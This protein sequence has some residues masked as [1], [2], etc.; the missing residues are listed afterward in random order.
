M[1]SSLRRRAFALA[2]SVAVLAAALVAPPSA[3]GAGVACTVTYTT[4]DWDTGFTANVA[5]R[6]DGP[7]LDGWQ[8]G[9]TFLDGQQI[10]QGWSATVAQNGAV[11]EYYQATKDARAK[12]IL[13]KW[14]PW[15]IAGTGGAFQIPS[16]L[17]WTGAPETWNPASPAA[18]TGLHVAIQNYSQDVGV[19]ASLAKTLLYYAAGS[20]NTQARTVGEQLLTA[21]AADADAKGIAVPETRS[22][23]D[24]FDD[25]YNANTDQGL[26]VPSGWTGT[27][28]NGDQINSNSTFVSIRSFYT[29][30][31]QWP[32]VQSYLNG[33]PAP[34]FTYHRFWAQAE[35]A[36]AFAA[37]V[38]LFS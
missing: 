14:I 25:K 18:N 2:A 35:I 8:V 33:G 7:P 28:P 12:K 29:N 11:A 20:G 21:L 23:Y 15:A 27:M 17:A 34:T 26:Y 6:D 1:R 36:T 3:F 10:Q 5:L 31:Q 13:D 37:Q 32:K 38:D 30:H 22:D 16:D 4:N 24:R 9:W 19:A